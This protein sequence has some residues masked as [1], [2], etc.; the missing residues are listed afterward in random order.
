MISNVGRVDKKMIN[1]ECYTFFSESSR[2]ERKGLIVNT[3]YIGIS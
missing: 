1:S 2:L 3:K